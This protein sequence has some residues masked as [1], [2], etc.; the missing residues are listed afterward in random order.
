MKDVASLVRK[1]IKPD[2]TRP[3]LV[4]FESTTTAAAAW[5][6]ELLE[7]T[8]GVQLPEQLVE[9]WNEVS[10]LRLFEDRE[11]GQWGLVL[12]PPARA[13]EL[14]E[15][16]AG[17]RRDQIVPGDLVVG[18]FL[19]DS[20]LVLIRCDASKADFGRVLVERPIDG[21]E[22]WPEVGES[23]DGFLEKYTRA[24]GEKFWDHHA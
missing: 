19:G 10:S 16:Q 9:I 8:L 5:S 22:F 6:R 14:T 13:R 7:A 23:I 1:A 15:Q 3:F 11:Y 24:G 4:R 20:D 21:R 17:Q 2:L 12:G 18:E